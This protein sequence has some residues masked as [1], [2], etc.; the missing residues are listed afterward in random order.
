MHSVY[1]YTEEGFDIKLLSDSKIDMMARQTWVSHRW[2]RVERQAQIK[3]LID[4]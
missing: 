4:I 3:V 1:S 2:V